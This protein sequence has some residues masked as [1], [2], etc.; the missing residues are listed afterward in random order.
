MTPP[1]FPSDPPHT[2]GVPVSFAHKNTCNDQKTEKVERNNGKYRSLKSLEFVDINV[3]PCVFL[4]FFAFFQ[5]LSP[6]L[7]QEADQSSH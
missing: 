3:A 4:S 1:L 2:K 5:T 6:I 7:V